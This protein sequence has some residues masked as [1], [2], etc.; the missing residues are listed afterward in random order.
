MTE[1]E[2]YTSDMQDMFMTPGWKILIGEM[3]ETVILLSDIRN[4]TK[5]EQLEFNKGMLAM[6]NSLI[7][8]PYEIESSEEE[9]IQ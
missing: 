7:N 1:E 8:L 4:I 6:I 5:I 9:T 3:Q 2:Q